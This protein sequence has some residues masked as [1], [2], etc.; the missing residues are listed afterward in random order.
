MEVLVLFWRIK[1][2]HGRVGIGHDGR[3]RGAADVTRAASI[4]AAAI[5]IFIRR[6]RGSS[7]AIADDGGRGH[8]GV[9]CR[10]VSRANEVDRPDFVSLPFREMRRFHGAKIIACMGGSPSVMVGVANNIGEILDAM[11]K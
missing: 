6:P 9:P 1:V 5:E 7:N 10:L 2:F 3:G 8:E 4:I 11:I